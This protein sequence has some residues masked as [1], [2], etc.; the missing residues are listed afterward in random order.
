MSVTVQRFVKGNQ[1][2]LWA[3]RERETMEEDSF[4]PGK[5][6]AG[7]LSRFYVENLRPV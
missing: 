5:T 4:T 7:V 3:G 6:S 2:V 1:T